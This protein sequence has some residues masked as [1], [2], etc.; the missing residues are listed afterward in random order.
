MPCAFPPARRGGEA[1]RAAGGR[2]P[3]RDAGDLAQ[4]GLPEA[5]DDALSQPARDG[6]GGGVAVSS[7]RRRRAARRVRQDHARADHG[8]DFSRNLPFIFVPAGPMLRGNW[9]GQFLGSGSD[10]WK[11]WAEKRAGNLSEEQW[12][13]IEDGI[14]RSPGHCMTMGT[15]S[16]MTSVA[17]TL[18]LH[19]AGRVV[20]SRGGLAALADGRG[21]RAADRRECVGG[22]EAARFRDARRRSTMRS[23]RSWRSAVR[24]M[25]SST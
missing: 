24:P 14:A 23:R 8:R 11:Y 4:R 10:V 9:R 15:A 21:V 25:R 20:D 3:A 17:E 22:S 6:D 19:A 5:D 12:D 1:R 13:A 2:L 16:T 18:G 7:G